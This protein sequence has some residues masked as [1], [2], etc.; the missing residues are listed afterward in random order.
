MIHPL[1]R[2]TLLTAILFISSQVF[3]SQV[4]S[5]Q[6]M[7]QVELG[8]TWSDQ[9]GRSF[10]SK[11]LAGHVTLVTLAYTTC[12]TLCP[13]VAERVK[14]V[15]EALLKKNIKAQVVLVSIDPDSETTESLNAWLKS[16]R[17]VRE[18]W[19]FIK[20][21]LKETQALAGVVGQGFSE[22]KTPEHIAHTSIL[23]IIGSD[24]KLKTTIE[25]MNHEPAEIVGKI[26]TALARR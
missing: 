7:A 10:T 22:H 4:F 6:N 23:A 2:T 19:Y 12:R 26:Q 24:G 11:R 3:S 17:L 14:A 20:G 25:L 5:G 8:G 18:R 15:D 9:T 1:M 16:R 21:S 13:M